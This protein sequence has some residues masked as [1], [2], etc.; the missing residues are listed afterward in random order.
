M[1][2][3]IFGIRIP[4]ANAPFRLMKSDLVEKYIIRFCDDY[5]LPNVML[6]TFL[7]IIMKKLFLKIF[8]LN[9]EAAESIRLTS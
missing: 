9:R 8:H 3:L 6:T 4:D 2:Y 5:N 1:H 7:F